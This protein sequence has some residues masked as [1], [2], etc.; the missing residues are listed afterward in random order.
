MV[1]SNTYGWFKTNFIP[2][3]YKPH[4]QII[5]SQIIQ[6]TLN[7]TWSET[8]LTQNHISMTQSKWNPPSFV[9]LRFQSLFVRSFPTVV[10]SFPIVLFCSFETH[11]C[12]V[13]CCSFLMEKKQG[14][15]EAKYCVRYV[16]DSVRSCWCLFV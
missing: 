2:N 10:R 11:L 5:C 4:S 12:F 1:I 3:L 6:W 15:E 13:C 7:Y 8:H 9:L 16:D 14:K